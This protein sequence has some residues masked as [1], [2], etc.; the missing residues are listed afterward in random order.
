MK[1]NQKYHWNAIAFQEVFGTKDEPGIYIKF[2]SDVSHG[3][4]TNTGGPRNPAQPCRAD[5]CCDVENVLDAMIKDRKFL[6]RFF[7]QYILGTNT[8]TK[9]EQNSITQEIGQE[10]RRRKITPVFN[11]FRVIRRKNGRVRY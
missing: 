1:D 5:F 8:L 6:T 4:N 9:R 11:Y 10:L 3:V 7:R 2:K